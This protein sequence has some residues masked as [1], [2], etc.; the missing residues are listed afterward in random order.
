MEAE[1]RRG[2][3]PPAITQVIMEPHGIAVFFSSVLFEHGAEKIFQSEGVCPLG[4]P[5]KLRAL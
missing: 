2:G 3:D 4:L 1:K 5:K